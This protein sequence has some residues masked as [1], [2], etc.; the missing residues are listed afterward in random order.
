MSRNPQLSRRA[1]LRGIGTAVALPLLD[2]MQP[3]LAW[4]APTGQAAPRRMAFFFV[5]NGV[6]MPDW[7][8]KR[9]GYDYDLPFILEP[10]GA[11]KND[12]LVLSGLTHDKGRV[13]SDGAGDHARSASVFLT[14]SQPRKT[15]GAN[16][17]AGVSVDQVAARKIGHLTRFP[18]LELGCDRGANAGSCDSGYSCAYSSNISWRSETAPVAKE[19]NPRMVFERLFSNQV[20]GEAAKSLAKRNRYRLSILDFVAE[21]ARGL[22]ARLGTAD[23]RKL[24]QYLTSIREIENRLAQTEQRAQKLAGIEPPDGVPDEYQDH[25]RLMC[26]M[27][28][29]AFQADLTRVATCMFAGAGSNRSYRLVG[30]PDGHHDLSHHGGDPVKHAKIRKINRFH[31]TQFAYFLNRLKSIQEPDGGSLLD[32]CMIVYGS[33]LSDGD[34][35][36]NENL[37]VFLAGHG[38]GTLR[39]GRHVRY[40]QETPMT[41]LFISMLDRVGAAT[42]YIGDSTGRLPDLV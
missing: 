23:Q 26:D 8:P 2:A 3:S 40:D 34:L 4:A 35:H 10:L 13:N 18:S 11:L 14:G 1:V 30:V 19:I 32:N 17:R 15:H 21:D 39:G 36:N 31:V 38:G 16:I 12:I 9:V 41:N 25:L 29:L 22:Q 5:P 7:T 27:L 24:D 42:D 33:G 20:T 28:V 37:P 6:H